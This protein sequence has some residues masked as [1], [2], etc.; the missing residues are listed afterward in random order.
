MPSR[1]VN[2]RPPEKHERLL[3]AFARSRRCSA[4]RTDSVSGRSERARRIPGRAPT[5]STLRGPSGCRNRFRCPRAPFTEKVTLLRSPPRG[6][7]IKR[8]HNGLSALVRGTGSTSRR[9]PIPGWLG[10]RNSLP[11]RRTAGG[12]LGSPRRCSGDIHTGL[13]PL[14]QNA[15]VLQ[16]ATHSLLSQIVYITCTRRREVRKHFDVL[17]E[18]SSLLFP[19][20]SFLNS[21]TKSET[22]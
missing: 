6:R 8:G 7:L 11:R 9:S 14:F 13:S 12:K 5:Q 17:G 19:N 2:P 22:R 20:R 10:G 1:S 16:V 18:K 21:S 3:D 15:P 4:G